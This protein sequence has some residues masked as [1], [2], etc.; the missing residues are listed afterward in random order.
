MDVAAGLIAFVARLG[1]ERAAGQGKLAALQAQ[2]DAQDA[3]IRQQAVELD[4][5][6]R[7][8]GALPPQERPHFAPHDRLTILRLMWLNGCS[9]KDA[10]KRFVLAVATVHRWL[11][12]W[13]GQ[14]DPGL[15]FGQVPWNK[16][17]DAVRSLIHDCRIQFPEPE[18]GTR[19]IAAQ[20]A[21]AAIA[22]SRATVQRVLREPPPGRP[23]RTK[24]RTDVLPPAA[25]PHHILKP[26]KIN[27]TWHL[28]L[29]V[30]RILW[31]H[32]HV[33]ALLDGYSRKLLA[34]RVFKRT[35]KAHDMLALAKTA[36]TS[37][38]LPRFIVTDHGCQ[39]HKRFTTAIKALGSAHVRGKV[40]SYRFNGKAERLF[41]TLKLWQRVAMF[42]LSASAIQQRLD[43]FR[44]WYNA[45]RCHQALKSHTPDEAWSSAARAEPA[46][47]HARD[48]VQPAFRLRRLS[49][50]GDPHLPI[51]VIQI[52][53]AAAKVA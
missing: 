4:M 25:K 42:F 37:Y 22:L 24:S 6:R 19:T 10:A 18:I 20:I 46:R 16:L 9:A 49:H 15:F 30:I 52:V 8:L 50:N 7:R 36:V 27:R 5:F 44:G 1:R 40:R 12:A 38:G 2:L 47:F 13:R 14:T 34:L 41:R 45:A 29:T 17:A 35:P 23:G 28:D 51:I 11:K 39:F 43:S 21:Q 31:F 3:L 48:R 26:Q 53:R 33:A 32:F